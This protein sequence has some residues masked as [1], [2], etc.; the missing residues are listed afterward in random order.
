MSL[1]H[2]VIAFA[3]TDTQA[4][5]HTILS[6][7]FR[8]RVTLSCAGSCAGH[9]AVLRPNVGMWPGMHFQIHSRR[10]Y[11]QSCGCLRTGIF[12]MQGGRVG[13]SGQAGQAGQIVEIGVG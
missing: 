5:T 12:G 3:H 7:L 11:A 8:T 1:F 10:V 13:Q 6:V 2:C 4:H 9:C